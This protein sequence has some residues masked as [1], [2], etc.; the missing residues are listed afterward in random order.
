MNTEEFRQM[1]E[2]DPH[3]AVDELIMNYLCSLGIKS[4][5]KKKE[6]ERKK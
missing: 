2:K 4:P 1:L 5:P 3:D 6:S